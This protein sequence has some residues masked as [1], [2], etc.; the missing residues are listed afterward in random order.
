M[1]MYEMFSG[2]VP[3]H[4]L[5]NPMEMVAKRATTPPPKPST[6]QPEITP[7]LE[8]V[9]LKA[10]ALNPAERYQSGAELAIALNKS[11][12]NLELSVQRADVVAEEGVAPPIEL[13]SALNISLPNLE[14]PVERVEA[15]AKGVGATPKREIS[16]S[17]VIIDNPAPGASF[18]PQTADPSP[19]FPNVEND[20]PSSNKRLFGLP[21]PT[22]AAGGCLLLILLA[23][24][25]I[26][27]V[28]L[29]RGQFGDGYQTWM[30][31]TIGGEQEPEPGNESYPGL[32]NP[33]SSEEGSEEGDGEGN[34]EENDDQQE[35]E[36]A[37]PQ[38]GSSQLRIATHGEDSFY[39]IN[40]GDSAVSL[41]A[42]L[43]NDGKRV[44]GGAGWGISTLGP[45]ECVSIWKDRGN[46]RGPNVDCNEIGDRVEVEPKDAFW[47]E[48]FDIV[49]QN[50]VIITC[51]KNGCEFSVPNG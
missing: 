1:V 28:Q 11:L 17:P 4:E 36:G 51:P 19:A 50:T 33:D 5:K 25:M 49:F 24:C 30:P 44:F 13:V 8:A 23:A 12:P 27:G 15:V 9:I 2:E 22:V 20:V 41:P 46:P 29:I 47:K 48:S 16:S 31:F 43:F 42:F 6:I 18:M 7:E 26:G 40:V 38:G 37:D 35:D 14:S 34:E 45:G 32:P 39:L 10:L 3:F 21:F